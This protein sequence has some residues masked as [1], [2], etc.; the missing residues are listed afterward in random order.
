MA[1]T[2][3]G[4]E[5]FAQENAEFFIWGKGTADEFF[6]S[7]REDAGMIFESAAPILRRQSRWGRAVEIGAG[8]GRLALPMSVG[9][10]E[11]V[12]VDVSPTMLETLRTNAGRAAVDNVRTSLISE[13]WDEAGSADFVYSWTVFQ[14]LESWAEIEDIVG[15]IALALKPGGA[16]ALQ[17]DT[18]PASLAYRLRAAVPDPMMPKVWR[19]SIRRVR[20]QPADLD[21]L[22]ARLGLT[23]ASESQRATDLHLYILVRP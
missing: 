14:H 6:S 23:V 18:R 1:V 17:F 2:V 10:R 7:G 13:R 15:R 16:A 5:L 22:F 19:K 8:T 20:R 9:F 3:N 4:W 21:K 11:V 12:A